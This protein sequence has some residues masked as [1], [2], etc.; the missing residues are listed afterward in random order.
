MSLP[1][2]LLVGDI[3]FRVRRLFEVC[4]VV[5][6]GLL[7]Q[8]RSL[9]WFRGSFAF[10]GALLLDEDGL[11]ERGRGVGQGVDCSSETPRVH[12][13]AMVR[14]VSV[15][16]GWQLRPVRRLLL[17]RVELRRGSGIID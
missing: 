11:S 12:E 5:V 6:S 14:F 9:T 3:S 1:L 16:A 13:M 15:E 8:C 7:P 2:T 4:A 10:V 17:A